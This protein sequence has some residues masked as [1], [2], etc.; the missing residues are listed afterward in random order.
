MLHMIIKNKSNT[1]FLFRSR[2]VFFDCDII[3]RKGDTLMPNYNIGH[4][5]DW[6]EKP[7]FLLKPNS[8]DT[9][10]FFIQKN[11]YYSLDKGEY[12]DVKLTYKNDQKRYRFLER[13]FKRKR[14]IT[15]NIVLNTIRI[16]TCI[17]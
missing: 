1:D 16:V 6:A 9:I 4:A 8:V 3:D 10:T 5:R 15:G 11:L 7:F 13:E 12:Y 17:Q 14:L 2:N